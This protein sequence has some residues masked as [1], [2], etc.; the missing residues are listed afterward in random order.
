M[1]MITLAPKSAFQ[2]QKALRSVARLLCCGLALLALPVAAGNFGVSPIS[3][4]LDRN[5][6]SGAISVSNDD[7]DPL[8]VQIRL[9]EWT[10]DAVGKDE[11]R[12]SE[13]LIYFPKLMV[14]DKEQQKLVRVGLRTPAGAQEK[15]YRL[16]VEEL[17]GPPLPGAPPGAR[18]VMKV[19]FGVPVFVKPAMPE[20][21]G[22]IEKIEMTKG[23]LRVVVRNTGNVHFVVSALAVTG[24][25]AWSKEVPGWYLLAGRSH[26]YAIPVAPEM[27]KKLAR[28]DVT[29]KTEQ[30]ELK[31][32]LDIAASM[33]L[34]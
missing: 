15:T 8:R 13:D 11:Y 1:N 3:L 17:P 29:A 7:A 31:G 2:A 12:E 18:V 34:P 25:G 21:H 23:M 24:G 27:C 20:V 28:I 5:A 10:Q 6:K 4:D 32:A 9:F 19:R 30:F 16:F 22:E 14:L 26:E 33:C